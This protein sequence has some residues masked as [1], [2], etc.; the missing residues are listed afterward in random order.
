MKIGILTH[1]L[2]TN[3][4]GI[5][6]AYALQVFLKNLDHEVTIIDRKPNRL[7]WVKKI[8]RLVHKNIFRHRYLSEHEYKILS[9]H[10]QKFID[11]YIEPKTEV[12]DSNK[13]ML[14]LK[15]YGFDA[16]I[17]GSDQVW[18]TAY[19]AGRIKNYF[20]D[21]LEDTQLLRLSYAA[22]FGTDH[23]SSSKKV[24]TKVLASLL[25]KFNAVSVREDSG[26]DI[27]NK[28]FNTHAECHIDPTMLLDAKDYCRLA[29]TEE[30]QRTPHDL[31]VYMLD[32]TEVN[33]RF[34][35]TISSGMG[36]MPYFLYSNPY[37]TKVV[38]SSLPTVTSWIRG[39]QDANM[40]ITDSFH[41][42]VFSILFNKPFWVLGNEKRGLAR[43]RSL[44]TT[45]GLND[46]LV[47][48]VNDLEEKNLKAPI[49]YDLV[50]LTLDE[51]R[52]EAHDYL[53]SNLK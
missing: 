42:A 30:E 28:V 45:F 4:G 48:S 14:R 11:K 25:T 38:R 12:I 46:R 52:V 39:F 3:Y 7:T 32:R 26:V 21:F 29:D 5:L 18:R 51:K 8:K 43:F 33:M 53:V 9:L 15:V 36:W 10:T 50:N 1:P 17:V 41:G 13:G 22:S 23:W 2:Q 19:V 16:I 6:Q 24:D 37:E 47:L 27:C 34:V 20:L 31:F 35:E 44:L 40:V 49:R